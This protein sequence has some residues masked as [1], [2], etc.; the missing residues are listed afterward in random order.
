M[1]NGVRENEMCP[2]F[3]AQTDDEVH[4]DPA[5][6]ADVAWVDWATFR[7]E[8]SAGQ[9]AVSPWCEQ[10][11]LDLARREQPDGRFSPGDPAGL[12]PAAR[13]NPGGSG[14]RDDPDRRR[15]P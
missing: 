3:V 6:V 10:Q 2:V 7:A 14:T 9:R 5:E 1:P 4:A 11:V 8:V 12:P 15:H 13:M